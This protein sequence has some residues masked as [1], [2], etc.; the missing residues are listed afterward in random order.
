MAEILVLS[1]CSLTLKNGSTYTTFI[2]DGT[3]YNVYGVH[4]GDQGG[5][6]FRPNIT[7]RVGGMLSIGAG[8]SASLFQYPIHVPPTW[9]LTSGC[10]LTLGGGMGLKYY[11]DDDHTVKKLDISGYTYGDIGLGIGEV[12][13]CYFD[14]FD[15]H[16][17]NQNTS[18][19]SGW[20]TV[21]VPFEAASSWTSGGSTWYDISMQTGILCSATAAQSS[22]AID[23]DSASVLGSAVVDGAT[24]A[25]VL[26]ALRGHDYYEQMA[27]MYALAINSGGGGI[28]DHYPEFYVRQFPTQA[29]IDMATSSASN[30]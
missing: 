29:E 26:D 27:T 13:V 1:G 4:I 9:Y 18:I 14:S 2:E 19:T 22:L 30:P 7:L 25:N 15:M 16:P 10:T 5:G 23:L 24:K 17:V 11:E 3:T 21:S 20:N 8:E 28:T 12:R 6:S